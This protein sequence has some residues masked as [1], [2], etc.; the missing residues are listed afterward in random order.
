MCLGAHS[1]WIERSPFSRSLFFLLHR[2]CFYF[3]VLANRKKKKKK[4]QGEHRLGERER[5]R[6]KERRESGE[7]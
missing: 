2:V 1:Q 4:A 6:E 3:F 7:F 5:E